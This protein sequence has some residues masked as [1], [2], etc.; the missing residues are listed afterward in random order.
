MTI[1]MAIFGGLS[2]TI[3]GVVII[4]IGFLV[5]FILEEFGPAAKVNI[6][7]FCGAWGL[8]AQLIYNHCN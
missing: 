7:L 8:L 2:F 4:L 5:K 1:G 3:V 6:I